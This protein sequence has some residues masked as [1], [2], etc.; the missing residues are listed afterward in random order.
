LKR[1]IILLAAA[2]VWASTGCVN[3]P[4]HLNVH[5]LAESSVPETS[6]SYQVVGKDASGWCWSGWVYLFDIIP[7]HFGST[8]PGEHA[9]TDALVDYVKDGANALVN[10]TC[11]SESMFLPIPFIAIDLNITAVSGDAV[12]TT[13]PVAPKGD[14]KTEKKK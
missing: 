14:A 4:V 13:Q 7:I 9:R 11:D 8:D 3:D 10:V 2:F 12:K 5:G 6:A 1:V